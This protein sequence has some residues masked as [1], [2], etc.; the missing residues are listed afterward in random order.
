MGGKTLSLLRKRNLYEYFIIA[1]I[2]GEQRA[3]G[4]R[5]RRTL[6]QL[7]ADS[8][9][10]RELSSEKQFVSINI[11]VHVCVYMCV[12]PFS[13]AYVLLLAIWCN[14]NTSSSYNIIVI[15]ILCAYFV[16]YFCGHKFLFTSLQ[17]WF[18]GL[19]RCGQSRELQLLSKEKLKCD[20]LGLFSCLVFYKHL[21]MSCNTQP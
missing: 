2:K 4:Q 11:Y 7:Q 15:I 13:I 9:M 21:K 1:L 20:K 19:P 10:A 16:A 18:L 17:V 6:S 12:W 8:Q 3:C 14:I 5:S